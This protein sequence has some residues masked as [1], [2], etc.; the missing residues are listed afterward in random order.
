MNKKSLVLFF[1]LVFEANLW[2]TDNF[3]FSL[4]SEIGILNG[5]I[6]EYVISTSCKNTDNILSKLDWEVSNIPFIELNAS[7]DVLKY[8]FIG[9]S[10]R[11]G[12][13]LQSGYMQDYDWLNSITDQWKADDPTELTNYSK[14]TN[15]LTSYN[16]INIMAGAN[17]I[18]NKNFIVT[19]FLAWDYFFISFDGIGGYKI[20]KSD[21]F[22]SKPYDDVK[23]ITYKQEFNSFMLGVNFKAKLIDKIELFAQG[24]ICPYVGASS[25]LD[26]HYRN[27]KVGETV[28]GTLYLDQINNYFQIKGKLKINYFFDIHNSIGLGFGIEYLPL[29]TGSDFSRNIDSDGNITGKKW[30]MGNSLGGTSRLLWNCSFNYQLKLDY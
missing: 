13:P 5:N 15:F 30:S 2:A 19:P 22:N 29:S 1:A 20:Y 6:Y 7:A 3:N 16:S 18:I 14:H 27:Q 8:F 26:Y 28:F 24:M 9:A 10:G 12:I 11:F 25:N 17:I 23:V 21:D 4:S